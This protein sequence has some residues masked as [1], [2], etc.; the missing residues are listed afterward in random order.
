MYLNKNTGPIGELARDDYLAHKV[1][2][3]VAI[4]AII[5]TSLLLTS[6][7]TAGLSIAHTYS[8]F[9]DAAPGPGSDGYIIGTQ[10]QYEQIAGRSDV[11]WASFVREASV[12]P[13]HNPEFAGLEARLFAPD[14]LFYEKNYVNLTSGHFPENGDEV[15]LSQT[16]AEKLGM[17]QIPGQKFTLAVAISK[18]DGPVEQKMQMTVC[19]FYK[20]PLASIS[21]IYEELYTGTDFISQHNPHISPERNHIYVKLANLNPLLQKSDVLQSLQTITDETGAISCATKHGQELFI[22]VVSIIPAV[23]F[24]LFVVL[25]GYFLIYNVFSIS[26]TND[27][28]WLGTLKTIGATPDQLKKLLRWQVRRLALYGI[29]IGLAAGYLFGE[30][31]APLVVGTLTQFGPYYSRTANPLIFLAA[32]LF[33]WMTVC[34]SARKPLKIAV[35]ISPAEAVKYT[36]KNKRFIFTILSFALSMAIFLT[37]Y[38]VTFGFQTEEMVERYNQE[39]YSITHT[40]ALQWLDEAYQPIPKE[41]PDQISRLPFVTNADTMYLARTMPDYIENA[42]GG[43]TYLSS[44][45]SVGLTKPLERELAPLLQQDSNVESALGEID[46]IP[47]VNLAIL[48]L[49]ADRLEQEAQ[50]CL[51]LDGTLDVAAFASGDYILYQQ[52]GS[53]H[54]TREEFQKDSTRIRAGDQLTIPFYADGLGFREKTVTVMAVLDFHPEIGQYSTGTFSSCNLILPD[55][56]FQEIYPDYEE[57]IGFIQISTKHEL[58]QEENSQLDALVQRTQNFQL[59]TKS[60][61]EERLE[62]EQ[63]KMTIGLL[64]FFISALFGLIGISNV[65]N[66]LTTSIFARKIEFAAMQSIGMT[67]KQMCWMLFWENVR[68]CTFSLAA[69]VPAGY[70]LAMNVAKDAYF[71]GFD[72]PSFVRACI[73]II[74]ACFILCA[75]LAGIL[76]HLLNKKSI[77]ERLRDVS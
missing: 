12:S 38:D 3:R 47:T 16:L 51:I 49:P 26:F 52:I 58:T 72:L 2:N 62:Y 14:P 75:L 22:A 74:I 41:L 9:T 67:K 25:C 18:P 1:R 21:T 31:I 34:I 70:L 6:V 20:N 32:G 42:A 19:G 28:H 46:G 4:L 73:F 15:L 10:E 64:G 30:L 63:S 5:L 8:A 45:G 39:D 54:I 27:I 29:P 17:E 35:S 50:Y 61:Y 59:H 69:A 55:T 68:L 24:A 71:T 33:S 76:T 36:P 77:V 37:A 57:R 13:L 40:A 60:T 11:D 53:Q 66:T 48:G 56:L 23:A 7:F 65:I 43:R 44:T